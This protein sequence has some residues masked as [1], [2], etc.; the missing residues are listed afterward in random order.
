MYDVLCPL[1]W[2][3]KLA[4]ATREELGDFIRA[5]SESQFNRE[6]STPWDD[7]FQS[8]KERAVASLDNVK[9]CYTCRR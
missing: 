6:H 8:R 1:Q 7:D 3:V 2:L 4:I 5:F 9:V